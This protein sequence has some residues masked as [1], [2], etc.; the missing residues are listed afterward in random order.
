MAPPRK[1]VVRIQ[2]I[3]KRDEI[4]KE[5]RADVKL[6]YSQ[7][8]KFKKGTMHFQNWYKYHIIPMVPCI[9]KPEVIEWAKIPLTATITA[10][11]SLRKFIQINN[12]RIKFTPAYAKHFNTEG[13]DPERD[14]DSISSGNTADLHQGEREDPGSPSGEHQA[15]EG[16]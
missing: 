13:A 4:F 8:R 15:P 3:G 9:V 6:A 5:W 11:M 12:V 16:G 2:I 7:Y 1:Y 10:G 14:R